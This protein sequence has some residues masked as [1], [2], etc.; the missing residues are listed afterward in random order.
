M[1]ISIFILYV[2][3]CV[4]DALFSSEIGSSVLVLLIFTEIP[5]RMTAIVVNIPMVNKI[6]SWFKLHPIKKE[7]IAPPKLAEAI[8]KLVTSST[9]F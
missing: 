1:S 3:Y 2:F 4:F 7:M 5:T 8:N 9:Y 6:V